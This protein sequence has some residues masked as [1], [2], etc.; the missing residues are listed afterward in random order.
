MTDLAGAMKESMNSLNDALK[1]SGGSLSLEPKK[2]EENKK[3]EFQL[4]DELLNGPKFDE[5]TE[6]EILGKILADAVKENAKKGAKKKTLDERVEEEKKKISEKQKGELKNDFE[7][8]SDYLK[9]DEEGGPT[10][11]EVMEKILK[12]AMKN[13][14]FR[15]SAGYEAPQSS[16]D[17]TKTSSGKKRKELPILR[18]SY[19]FSR[20]P[21]EFTLSLDKNHLE[22][23]F[24]K[25]KPLLEK[26][27]DLVKRRKVK[28]A[29]NYFKVVMDQDIPAE[30]KDM[31]DQN[32]KDLTEYLTKY[33]TS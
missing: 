2:P 21:D 23:S 11:E 13:R 8:M 29:I 17:Q 18:V 3:D 32:I 15:Q 4:M 10:D 28:D 5:P 25:F 27:N 30:F 16:G 22:Y 9:S 12:D 7:L 14:D 19:N 31:L 26:A 24:Y 6:E 1:S 20:L 33:Y